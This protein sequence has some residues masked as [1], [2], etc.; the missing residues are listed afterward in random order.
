MDRNQIGPSPRRQT[1]YGLG[2]ASCKGKE[3]KESDDKAKRPLAVDI[4]VVDVKP[5]AQITY[6]GK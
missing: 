3:P 2:P 6:G 4:S 5:V 1:Q